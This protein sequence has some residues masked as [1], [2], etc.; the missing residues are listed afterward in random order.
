MYI[1]APYDTPG[2][3]N[4]GRVKGIPNMSFADTVGAKEAQST[5]LIAVTQ[6]ERVTLAASFMCEHNVGSLVVIADD[7]DDTMVGIVTERDIIRWIG[8]ASPETYFQPVRDIMTRDVASCKP[9]TR[10]IDVLAEMKYRR[11]RHMPVVHK[12]KPVGM[13][14]LRDLLEDCV[15]SMSSLRH[16]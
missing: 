11:I 13:L 2:M 16:V 14:S 9:G 15:N 8:N 12:G 4:K 10:V 1:Q 3:V 7:D 6:H 5:E